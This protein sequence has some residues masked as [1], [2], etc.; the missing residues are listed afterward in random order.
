VLPATLERKPGV[1]TYVSGTTAMSHDFNALMRARAP[2]LFAFV[3]SLA[4]LLLLLTFRSL[5]IALTAV[6]LNLLSVGAAYGILVWIFQDG[7]LESV[8]DFNSIGGITSWLPLF[9][10]VILF[11]CRWT[12]TC[13]SS[14]G[15]ARA[16]IAA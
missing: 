5:V 14:A 16:T 7:N 1:R 12:T 13:S 11:G 10:F 15:S 3:L 9:L 2:W 6:V 4:F 8:L